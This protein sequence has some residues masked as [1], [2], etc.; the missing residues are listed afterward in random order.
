[1]EYSVA[2]ISEH[3]PQPRRCDLCPLTS[4][5]S[6]FREGSM[7]LDEF[8]AVVKALAKGEARELRGR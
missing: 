4:V 8:R 2:P 7:E 6:A 5:D 3:S 1:L